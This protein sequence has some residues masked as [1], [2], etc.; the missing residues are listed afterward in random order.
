[1]VDDM[2]I[3]SWIFWSCVFLIGYTYL[4][5]PLAIRLLARCRRPGRT[6]GAVPRSVSF[7]MA[8]RNE[9]PRILERVEELLR[10]I[11]SA[12]VE[13]EVVLV[14]DG[15]GHAIDTRE[16]ARHD[17]LQILELP[18]NGGKSAAISE[19]AQ[20][21]RYDVLAF[22]DVRQRWQDDALARLLEPLADPKV[23]AVSGD[24]IIE[25]EPGVLEGV[26]LYWRYEKWIRDNEARYDSPVGVSGSISAVRRELFHGVPPGA[27]LDDVYW[28][29]RVVMQGYR[30]ARTPAAVAFDRLPPETRAEFRRKTRTLAGNFQLVAL[31]PS[32]LVPW[33]NRLWWQ[34]VSHKLMRLLVPW[35]LIT[36]V[37]VG[38]LGD[39]GLYRILSWT[40]LGAYAALLIATQTGMAARSRSVSAAA[41][42]AMLNLAAWY[43][44]WIWISGRAGRSWNATRYECPE[45]AAPL[46]QVP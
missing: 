30:V 40:Q 8:A 37:V 36:M 15:P 2:G 19:G 13:G 9:G 23:G 17:R 35:L 22:A 21:A 11:D 3:D 24:V 34:F 10:Q 16:L 4:L 7:V 28:P 27:V 33:K 26:G 42:F 14:L 12:G 5:Y 32:L 45:N 39:A 43:A 29:M 1:M 18:H 38:F 46:S 25:S 41:S 44:F 31:L 6:S 20:R